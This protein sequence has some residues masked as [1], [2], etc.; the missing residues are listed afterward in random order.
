MRVALTGGATGIG[1]EVAIK[2]KQA[3]HEVHAFD[4][5]EPLV[6]VDVWIKTDL[7]DEQSICAALD[8][9]TGPYDALINNAGLPPRDGLTEMILRVNFFGLRT[10][11]YGML[12]K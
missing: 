12:S 1:S 9:A 2:L 4:I 7:N 5:N 6:D 10:F 8:T 3:G 11:L